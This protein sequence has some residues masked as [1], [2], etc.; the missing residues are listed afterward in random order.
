MVLLGYHNSPS[1][2]AL[3]YEYLPNGTLEDALETGVRGFNVFI[4]RCGTPRAR[5][6]AAGRPLSGGEDEDKP[7]PSSLD[8]QNL[9][10]NRHGS[11]FGLS[12]HS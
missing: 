8:V 7:H 9:H 1:L 5:A 12:P 3:V 4:P 6:H 2:K 10:S 11:R